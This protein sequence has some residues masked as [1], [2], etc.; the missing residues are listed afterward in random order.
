MC[1]I[2]YK[3]NGEEIPSR[4]ILYNCFL[5][6]PDGIGFMYRNNNKVHI[7]K[8]FM[9][10][11]RFMKIL[12]GVNERTRG[13]RGL[14]GLKNTELVIH[15][16]MATHGSVVPYQTHPFPITGNP[17]V[18]KR[19]NT[20]VNEALAHNGILLNYQPT[21]ETNG[22]LSDTM[23][24]I[25]S[26]YDKIIPALEFET[27]NKFALMNKHG[28]QLFGKFV[29]TQGCFFSNTGFLK[30]IS[31]NDTGWGSNRFFHDLDPVVAECYYCGLQFN[32]RDARY[33][34]EGYHICPQCWD[35]MIYDRYWDNIMSKKVGDT[36]DVGKS[37]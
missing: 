15:F 35:E 26:N 6:N 23:I 2:I 34:G 22:S 7:K 36:N 16:R 14:R 8:G 9:D 37:W 19:C 33:I 11:E 4:E 27:Q 1:I 20:T 17:R 21:S 12:D 28:T 25:F 29:V 5:N 3:P 32:L 18:L 10:F 13:S 31:S 24:F 30:P